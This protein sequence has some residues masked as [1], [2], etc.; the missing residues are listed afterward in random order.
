LEPTPSSL[1][2]RVQDATGV[3]ARETLES[4]LGQNVY[5]FGDRT[6][7]R[8]R[9][10]AGDRICFY[11]SSVG[12][13][14]DAVIASAAERRGIEFAKDAVNWPWAF[15]VRDVRYYFDSPV[16]I[17]AALRSQLDAFVEHGH[18]PNGNWSWIVQGTRYLTAHDFALVTGR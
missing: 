2:Q 10:K 13:V 8:N 3:T 12:V 18:D 14:A 1:L 16:A 11:W 7:G 17:D 5:V 6:P 9:I 15:A 4:L